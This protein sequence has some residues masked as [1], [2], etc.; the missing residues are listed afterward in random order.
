MWRIKKAWHILRTGRYTVSMEYKIS[1]DSVITG[2][3]D[4]EQVIAT[5]D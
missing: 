4:D 2:Y 1:D 5:D 3:I